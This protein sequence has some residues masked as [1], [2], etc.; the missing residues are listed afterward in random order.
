MMTPPMWGF[1]TDPLRHGFR[2]PHHFYHSAIRIR[3]YPIHLDYIYDT[4]H[5]LWPTVGA[6]RA[7]TQEL[8]CDMMTAEF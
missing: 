7:V 8:E 4:Q 6:A 3:I 1:P 2:L 5:V